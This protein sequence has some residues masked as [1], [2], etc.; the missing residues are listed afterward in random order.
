MIGGLWRGGRSL[1]NAVENYCAVLEKYSE[2]HLLEQVGALEERLQDQQIM[3]TL[4][5][6]GNS[7]VTKNSKPKGAFARLQ[8]YR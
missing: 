5:N 3:D 4:A 7:K 2:Q 6:L 1:C 8:N